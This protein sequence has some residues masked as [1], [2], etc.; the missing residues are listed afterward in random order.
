MTEEV[1]QRIRALIEDDFEEVKE[2]EDATI[3]STKN[4]LVSNC[5]VRENGELIDDYYFSL[6]FAMEKGKKNG[7]LCF[8][9]DVTYGN[10]R[11]YLDE[12]VA[13]VYFY[14]KKGDRIVFDDIHFKSKWPIDKSDGSQLLCNN[15]SFVVVGDDIF[16][17][18]DNAV[19]FNVLLENVTVAGEI[20]FTSADFEGLGFLI[21]E[22]DDEDLPEYLELLKEQHSKRLIQ[23][24]KEKKLLEEKMEE[25]IG[26]TNSEQSS[27]NW[28]VDLEIEEEEL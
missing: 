15:Y 27:K 8:S 10:T 3:V 20:E 23:L 24:K 7:S 6:V 9:F 14:G 13:K 26:Y 17:I 16:S 28:I 1:K 12:N 5:K 19:S 4:T 2:Y 25:E 22:L 18:V 21:G 11:Q